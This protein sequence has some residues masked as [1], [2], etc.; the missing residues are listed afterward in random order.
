MMPIPITLNVRAFMLARCDKQQ[1]IDP[2][3]SHDDGWFQRRDPPGIVSARRRFRFLMFSGAS[4]SSQRVYLNLGVEF[5]E[6]HPV[7]HLRV[8]GLVRLLY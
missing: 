5:R 4:P 2:C 8:W 1:V 7:T 3:F 6:L